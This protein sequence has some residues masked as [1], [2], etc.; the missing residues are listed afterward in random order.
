MFTSLGVDLYEC[1]IVLILCFSLSIFEYK[2][3]IFGLINKGI[4]DVK[5]PRD[6]RELRKRGILK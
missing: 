3:L 4:S 1:T 6:L 5:F 2:P